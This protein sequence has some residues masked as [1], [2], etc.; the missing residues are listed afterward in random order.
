MAELTKRGT[1]CELTLC[2]YTTSV[3]INVSYINSLKVPLTPN[4]FFLFSKRIHN[5]VKIKK[6]L[7]KSIKSSR[8]Y[9][10]LKL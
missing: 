8:N 7:T 6:E 4:F 1:K 3:I 2:A 5:L 9:E 10:C